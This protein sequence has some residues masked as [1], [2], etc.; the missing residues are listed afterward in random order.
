MA[1]PFELTG[2][3]ALVTGAGKGIGRQTALA[4]ARQGA[5]VAVAARTASDLAEVASQIERIGRRSLAITVDIAAA[6]GPES[7]VG[8][9]TSH[10]DRLDILVNNAGRV[11][12]KR[13]E[14]T[15][16]DDWDA[17]LSLNI[18]GLAE[19]CRAALP[20]L[21]Q[22][23]SG[24]IV[25]MSSI[26]GLVGT[27]L[28]AAY[29]S[30]KMAIL[31]YTRVLARELAAERIRVNAVCPGFIDTDFVTPHLT[32]QPGAV[33][34]VLQH[35]PLGRMGTSEDVAWTIAFLATPAAA[36]ITGQS[37]VIDGGWTIA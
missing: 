7:A 29:A 37:I 20:Y 31:G 24:S 32:S 35:I 9:V 1:T 5:D 6:G 27:P 36:Y 2:R 33:E 14:E 15:V 34:S 12:R 19:T 30:T 13:A 8:R 17:V 22:S 3:V 18:V 11:V 16:P 4:L 28:R 23:D 26:T 25:N 10:F 21:R